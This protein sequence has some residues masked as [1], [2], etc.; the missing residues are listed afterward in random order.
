MVLGVG[1][2]TAQRYQLVIAEYAGRLPTPPKS[3]DGVLDSEN[4]STHTLLQ[5]VIKGCLED[6]RAILKVHQAYVDHR[7]VTSKQYHVAAPREMQFPSA[8]SFA[9][10]DDV[11][12]AQM[13][14][15]HTDLTDAIMEKVVTKPLDVQDLF[16]GVFQISPTLKM[17]APLQIR[18]VCRNFLALRNAAVGMPYA[19][20][21]Q[22]G[23]V[24]LL[25]GS[26][27]FKPAPAYTPVFDSTGSLV[28]I[29]FRNGDEVKC[30]FAIKKGGNVPMRYS[31]SDWRACWPLAPMPDAKLHLFFKKDKLGPYAP[32]F[33]GE[34]N[35][36]NAKYIEMVHTAFTEWTA[37]QKDEG[38]GS[39]LSK[40]VQKA[41]VVRDLATKTK[42]RTRMETARSTG[43]EAIKAKKA[44]RD[45]VF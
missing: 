27:T 10:L 25:D 31:W 45:E 26:L 9:K 7:D 32:G 20:L 17:L 36:K 13:L 35:P 44:R 37:G 19:T 2:E 30:T 39:K 3:G 18:D 1:S 4:N 24:N 12:I 41:Q 42:L 6:P 29:K 34:L 22:D 16:E 15:E 14:V 28:K 40:A 43:L 23:V 8:E 11:F 38:E 33:G 21:V 5:T